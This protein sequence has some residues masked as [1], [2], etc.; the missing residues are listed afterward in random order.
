M[1]EV[2]KDFVKNNNKNKN[3]FNLTK[4]INNFLKQKNK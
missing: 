3:N 1:K 2:I 4:K